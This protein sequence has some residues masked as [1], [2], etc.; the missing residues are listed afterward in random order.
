MDSGLFRCKARKETRAAWQFSPM[1]RFLADSGF[2]YIGTYQ[3]DDRVIKAHLR[4]QNFDPAVPSVLPLGGTYEMDVSANVQGDTMTGTAMVSNQ[5]QLSVG[6]RLTKK[7][8][9]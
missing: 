4:V 7:V 3:G 2:T 1:A 5:P 6:I 8:N 9:L